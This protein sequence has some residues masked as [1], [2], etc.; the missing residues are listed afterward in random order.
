MQRICIGDCVRVNGLQL[1]SFRGKSGVVAEVERDEK[2]RNDWDICAVVIESR[3]THYFP[4]YALDPVAEDWNQA[5][6]A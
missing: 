3:Y 6:A 5:K 2:N 4:A 1:S